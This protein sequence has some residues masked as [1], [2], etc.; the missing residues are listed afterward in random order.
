MRVPTEEA[1]MILRMS[2]VE[3]LDIDG[4]ATTRYIFLIYIYVPK[5]ILRHM[6]SYPYQIQSL[7]QYQSEYK[8]SV[9]D[10]EGFWGGIATNFQWRKPWDKVL[11][12]NFT[13]PAV[14]WF[15]G[16]QINITENC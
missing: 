8:K 15:S 9:E 3:L 6:S 10:P 5:S 13:E 2:L 12:W 7:E 1:T 14:R 4:I 11:Q 16:A